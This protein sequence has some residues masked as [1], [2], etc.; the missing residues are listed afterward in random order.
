M[1]WYHKLLYFDSIFIIGI[2]LVI[3][4]NG[5][6]ILVS[7]MCGFAFAIFA[8]FVVFDLMELGKTDN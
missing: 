3:A 4:L 7:I 6:N 2:P 5:G 1:K 8:H